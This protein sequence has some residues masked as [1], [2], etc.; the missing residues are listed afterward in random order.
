MRNVC[1]SISNH[2]VQIAVGTHVELPQN[3]YIVQIPAHTNYARLVRQLFPSNTGLRFSREME[4]VNIGP[5]QMLRSL[6]VIYTNFTILRHF[7][8]KLR[9]NDFLP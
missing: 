8:L 4:V 6:Y 1:S 5:F 7:L 2:D 3:C 9:H